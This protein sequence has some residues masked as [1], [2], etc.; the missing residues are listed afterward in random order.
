MPRPSKRMLSIT[1]PSVLFCGIDDY[2]NFISCLNE[3]ELQTKVYTF[4]S[5]KCD[6]EAAENLL[7]ETGT[8]ADFV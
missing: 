8:E 3:L 5:T 6:S 1:K 2:D 7:E 4:I